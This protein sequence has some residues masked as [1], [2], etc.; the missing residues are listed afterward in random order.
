VFKR[1]RA[2]CQVEA[3]PDEGDRERVGEWWHL[4]E[5]RLESGQGDTTWLTTNITITRRSRNRGH[6]VAVRVL[7]SKHRTTRIGEC[8]AYMV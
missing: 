3:L 8:P 6:P 4:A 1:Q 2:Q 7:G 5:S